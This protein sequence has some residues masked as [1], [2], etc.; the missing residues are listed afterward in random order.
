MQPALLQH[1][2]PLLPTESSSVCCC[3]RDCT[4]L[5]HPTHYHDLWLSLVRKCMWVAILTTKLQLLTS[6]PECT[7]QEQ[8]VPL[9][10]FLTA[11]FQMGGSD[12]FVSMLL[13]LIPLILRRI[14]QGERRFLTLSVY[15]IFSC[16]Q[17]TKKYYF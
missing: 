5:P 9:M 10:C 8:L 2:H 16:F 4:P 1:S 15:P 3:G 7:G 11:I 12:K 17:N 14:N 6:G 13:I